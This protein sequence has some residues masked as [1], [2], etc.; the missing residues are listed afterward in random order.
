MQRSNAMRSPPSKHGSRLR[1]QG[2]GG[3]VGIRTGVGAA[4]VRTDDDP[5]LVGL[6][7]VQ[8]RGQDDAVQE[9]GVR[10]GMDQQAGRR[11]QA[12]L[13]TGGGQEC[14]SAHAGRDHHLVG[15]KKAVARGEAAD[16]PAPLLEPERRRAQ[17]AGAV[18]PRVLEQ[19]AR[20]AR[21]LHGTLRGDMDREFGRRS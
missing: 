7:H 5:A 2:L 10:S 1:E 12:Q 9:P 20:G 13:D 3:G 21:R 19:G 6:P 18:G 16:P 11:V 15:G 17:Q 14:R 8:L 4:E